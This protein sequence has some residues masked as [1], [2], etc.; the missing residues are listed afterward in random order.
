[1]MEKKYWVLVASMAITCC[2]LHLTALAFEDP[3][4]LP[5]VRNEITVEFEGESYGE[6]IRLSSVFTAGRNTET[7]GF[8]EEKTVIT[9]TNISASVDLKWL[10]AELGYTVDETITSTIMMSNSAELNAGESCAFY[11]RDHYEVYNVDITT[12]T[13][14]PNLGGGPDKIE[15]TG[16]CK[17]INIPQ[18]LTS[19]DY[20]WM[21]SD[22]SKALKKKLTK[23]LE[24]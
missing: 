4:G 9:S 13:T 2:M 11:Y 5:T 18:E 15:T 20:C 1:M 6:W 3:Y 19:E 22:S 8:L 16:I 23:R 7:C 17:K 12:I 21:Y 24:K 10:S 14:Y